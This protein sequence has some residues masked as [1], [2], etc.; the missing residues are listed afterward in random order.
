MEIQYYGGNCVRIQTKKVSV[1]IDD[2]LEKLGQKSTTK[3]TDIEVLTSKTLLSPTSKSEFLVDTPGEYEI[4]NVSIHGVAARAHMDEECKKTASCFRLIIDD[5]R[6]GVLGHIY[7]NLNDEQLEAIGMVDILIVPVGGNGYTVDAVGALKLIKQVEP[8]LVIPTH[9][10]DEDLNYEVPQADL[11]TVRKTLS[12]EPA[13]EVD[14]L[15]LKGREF[16]EG[17]KLVILKR[18]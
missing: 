6:I 5:I 16:A 14:E 18:Q 7:P 17:T 10:D 8:R 11:D 2:N 15:K 3:P 4:R 12:M 1:V 9:Y 13:E